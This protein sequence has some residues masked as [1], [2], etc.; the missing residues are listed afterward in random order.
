MAGHA[1]SGQARGGN[2][3]PLVR[4]VLPGPELTRRRVG[5]V[6]A[7]G[8]QEP[9]HAQ[10]VPPGQ[11]ARWR[12]RRRVHHKA[13]PASAASTM[14]R[15]GIQA[16]TAARPAAES[17][18]PASSS[19][20]MQHAAQASPARLA[21]PAGSALRA[22][23]A[24]GP[25]GIAAIASNGIG[26]HGCPA[27]VI[28]SSQPSRTDATWPLRSPLTSACRL[29]PAARARPARPPTRPAPRRQPARCHRPG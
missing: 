19:G 24:S 21:S 26:Q 1:L 10:L 25:S 6:V 27:Q 2:R 20:R 11:L 5:V 17:T 14:A 7:Q 15:P 3:G 12:C 28:R 16:M 4:T 18:P 29:Q 13:V 23:S 8:C 9:P 22:R